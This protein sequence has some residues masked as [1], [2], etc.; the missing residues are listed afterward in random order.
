MHVIKI[1]FSL[2]LLLTGLAFH[3]RALFEWHKLTEDAIFVHLFFG[4]FC[5]GFLCFII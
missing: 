4:V 3:G 5:Y 1:V 2:I